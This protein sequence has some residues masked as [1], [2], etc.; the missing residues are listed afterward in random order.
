MS[1]TKIEWADKV[2]NP[3]VGC[4]KIS[5][6]CDNCYAER[7]AARLGNMSVPG[8]PETVKPVSGP[9]GGHGPLEWSGRVSLRREVLEKPWE[10]KQ[11]RRIFVYSMGDLFHE[12][13]PDKWIDRVFGV[14]QANPQHKFILLTKRPQRMADYINRVFAA[15]VFDLDFWMSNVWAGVT[16]ENQAAL[17]NR[18]PYLWEIPAAVRFVSAEPM[19]EN[20]D[21]GALTID[22]LPCSLRLNGRPL[23][24]VIVNWVI[25]GGESGPGARPINPAWV[26]GLR[27]QCMDA[28]VPFFFKQWGEWCPPEEFQ[29]GDTAYADFCGRYEIYCFDADNGVSRVGKKRAGRLLDGVTWNELPEQQEV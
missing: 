16:I 27:D 24:S 11:G 13:V 4:S 12:N 28:G 19:L 25:C 2:W 3:V 20:L 17:Q 21:F 1:S 5:A 15:R 14:I 8:Y 22:D 29:S 6:G 26:Y 9:K 23:W 10:W 18:L 7:M